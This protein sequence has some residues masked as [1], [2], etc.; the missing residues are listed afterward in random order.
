MA[1]KKVLLA[2][3]INDVVYQIYP[4]TSAD[5]VLYGETTV[6]A[7]LAGFTT[8]LKSYYTKTEAD[9]ATKT[10]CDELY[11]KIMGI[12]E[13]DAT[14]NEAYDTLK[15]VAAWIGE[16]GDVAAGF[17]TD[18]AT[19]KKVVGDDNS[20]LVK[21]LADANSAISTNTGDISTLK[22]SVEDLQTA[23]GNAESGLTKTVA[24]HTTAISELK[25]TVGDSSK[26][27]V[28]DVAD[29]KA[30]GATKVEASTTNGN[31]KI[32]DTETTVYTHPTTHAA[33]M[34]TEDDTHKFVTADEKSII[35]SAAA[36]KVV[37]SESS[38]ENDRD[39]YM[40]EISA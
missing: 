5:N 1:I 9:S 15:E 36:V 25:T 2:K 29:L 33:S 38:V 20:G 34:I 3:K 35:A 28:K 22:Q 27:L 6:A 17:T 37:S 12:T 4:K 40:V 39:L 23:V 19:L 8:D 13:G 32:N 24:D 26:G 21:A 14:I 18:I 7:A 16:H 31:I 11:N 30:A 10:A